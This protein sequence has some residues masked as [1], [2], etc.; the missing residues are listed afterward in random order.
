[1]K[2]WLFDPFTY[3]AGA[4]SLLLGLAAVLVASL[5]GF[6]GNTHFDGVVD[7]HTGHSASAGV[8]LL[9]GIIDWLSLASVLFIAGT[10][11]S[12]TA[13]RA[14]DLF[15]TQ[16]LARWPTVVT[17]SAAL[18]PPY[19]RL[20]AAIGEILMRSGSSSRPPV[21]D[22]VVFALALLFML[23]AQVFMVALMYR[24]YSLCC[25]LKGLTAAL[26]FTIGL[27]VAELISKLALLQILA[28]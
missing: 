1:V 15:G 27:L 22:L 20:V 17:A 10:V 3:I 9:E 4:R 7:V 13:F 19:Q 2:E 16:A 25:N 8:F 26:T 28:G 21:T 23:L 11:S 5:V 12:R 24:A 6:F 18:A 14:I